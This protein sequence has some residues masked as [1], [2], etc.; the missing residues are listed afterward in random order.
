MEK[1]FFELVGK[2][3]STILEQKRITQQ[4]LADILGVSKQVLSK[5]IKGQKAINVSEISMISKAL[6]VS[7]ESLLDVESQ[8]TNLSPQFSFMGELK[9]EK[10]KEKVD[11]LRHVIDEML[12]L[13]EYSNDYQ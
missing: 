11:F 12:F 5:I 10:T 7:I 4:N 9:K 3:I 13:E 1:M 8:T 2:N 6:G